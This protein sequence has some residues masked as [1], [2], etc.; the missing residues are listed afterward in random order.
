MP[1][2]SERIG[3][4]RER[5]DK[6]KIAAEEAW[7]TLLKRRVTPD[8]AEKTAEFAQGTLVGKEGLE[9][10]RLAAHD[11]KSCSSTSSDTSPRAMTGYFDY[12]L[13]TKRCIGSWAAEQ[14]ASATIR[15]IIGRGGLDM[16]RESLLE[17][18][19]R[20]K[21]RHDEHEGLF[22]NSEAAIRYAL[23][24]PL[25]RGLGWD[26]EDMDVVRP[27]FHVGRNLRA[28]Y[29]LIINRLPAIVV[30]CK[31]LN[32]LLPNR[33]SGVLGKGFQYCN[34]AGAKYLLLTDGRR[35]E[36]YESGKTR[37]VIYFDLKGDAP[38]T[39]CRKA[40]SLRKHVT[41]NLDVQPPKEGW[42][43]LTIDIIN[44]G[45][46]PVELG[47]PAGEP[48]ALNVWNDLTIESTRW[49][50]NNGHLT[51]RPLTIRRKGRKGKQGD[52]VVSTTHPTRGGKSVS[53][54]T[55]SDLYVVTDFNPDNCVRNAIRVIEHA[56]QDK[57][58]FSVRL[59]PKD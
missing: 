57:L 4:R 13:R 7:S 6:L 36:L 46:T 40:V 29:V 28:D 27:E 17:L 25:L 39:V 49:L 24:N 16:K 47:F 51:R 59:S 21:K 5:K 18:V 34:E 45:M 44:K 14:R 56:G 32:E 20:L 41:S 30:E 22:R 42:I 19:E 15:A 2:A 54:K 48:V 55:V 12:S 33:D 26:T 3:E 9:P 35:W 10:S 37:S 8:K 38:A 1:D 11:P 31:K 50:F 58:K 53:Y 43:P 52:V 23:I